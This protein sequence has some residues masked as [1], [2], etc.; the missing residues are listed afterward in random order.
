MTEFTEPIII[1]I[2]GATVAV[3]SLLFRLMYKSKC[4]DVQIGCIKIHRNTS[5]EMNQQ[6]S[7]MDVKI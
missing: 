5:Q 4:S 7:V 3:L 6:D 1:S 2:I